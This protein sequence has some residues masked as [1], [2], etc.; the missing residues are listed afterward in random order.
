M[1]CRCLLQT[2]FDSMVWKPEN[3]CFGA[4]PPK[5]M[6]IFGQKWPKIA[7]FGHKNSV[8]GHRC[9]VQ[10]PPTL[11]FGCL[12]QKNICCMILKPENRCFRAA[13]LKKWAFTS[14]KWPKN[15]N[16]GPK[17][18]FLGLGR[19]VQGPPTLF[20]RCLIQRKIGCMVWKPVNKCFGAAQPK[21]EPFFGK[22]IT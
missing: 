7:N 9:S 4:T 10:D 2:N 13:P 21:R 22:K 17:T 20:C 15:A 1:G 3:R 18:P 6:A 5:K 8:F 12:T 14:Q 11:F 16:N 19:S